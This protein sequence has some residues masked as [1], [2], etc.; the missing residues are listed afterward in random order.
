[1]P[2]IYTQKMIIF[3]PQ[4]LFFEGIKGK[5]NVQNAVLGPLDILELLNKYFQHYFEIVILKPD[6]MC[7]LE[8]NFRGKC[9][10][11]K[12]L[13]IFCINK[14]MLIIDLY[15][16]KPISIIDL[17][18][19]YVLHIFLECLLSEKCR[20]QDNANIRYF[21]HETVVKRLSIKEQRMKTEQQELV[22]LQAKKL[23]LSCPPS[24][25]RSTKF[26]RGWQHHFKW[27]ISAKS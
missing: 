16:I 23:I 14:I 4:Y 6:P 12:D 25:K 20:K 26:R 1:M 11:N 27:L 21:S 24:Q 13:H 7:S 9:G 2:L 18:H 22:E 17:W 8:Y 15:S 19:N 5:I 3:S 10:T